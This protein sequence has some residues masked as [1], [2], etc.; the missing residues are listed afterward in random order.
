M[1]EDY[2]NIT[3]DDY[4]SLLNTGVKPEDIA[5]EFGFYKVRVTYG[6]KSH[7]KFNLQNWFLFRKDIKENLYDKDLCK[8]KFIKKK[9]SWFRSVIGILTSLNDQKESDISSDLIKKDI[10]IFKK[11]ICVIGFKFNYCI[12]D[13]IKHPQF[14]LN[15]KDVPYYIIFLKDNKEWVLR[16][17]L[18]QWGLWSCDI[19]YIDEDSL[20]ELKIACSYHF[21]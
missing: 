5:E 4:M 10:V 15:Y 19:G 1:D 20:S 16:K 9:K 12:I 17:S 6:D 3:K 7:K 8:I 11:Y 21:K 14:V 18:S 13:N 2:L